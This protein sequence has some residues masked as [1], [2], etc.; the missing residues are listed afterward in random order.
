MIAD[1]FT[2]RPTDPPDRLTQAEIHRA[3]GWKRKYGY[4]YQHETERPE[5]LN[6]AGPR[7]MPTAEILD[8]REVERL[9]FVAATWDLTEGV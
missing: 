9:R 1:R 8:R 4:H 7:E 5:L 6:E 3:I 2:R